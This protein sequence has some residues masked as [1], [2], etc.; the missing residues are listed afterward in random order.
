MTRSGIDCY[1][2]KI[3]HYLSLGFSAYR[4]AKILPYS[5]ATILRF[6][7]RN[8]LVNKNKC[9]VDYDNL[10]KDKKQQVI[11]LYLE[12]KTTY[13]ISEMIGHSQSRVFMIVQEEGISR[14]ATYNVDETFFDKIDTQEKAYVLGWFYSEG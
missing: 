4:I 5:K 3:V 8:G 7:K 2:D 12:G 10:L 6:I 9:K 14:H 11:N 13:E 1:K